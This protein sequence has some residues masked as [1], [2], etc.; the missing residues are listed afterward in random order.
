[1]VDGRRGIFDSARKEV[2][3]MDDAV[4]FGECFLGEVLMYELDGVGEQESLGGENQQRGS[5]GSS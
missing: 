5:S 1:M 3:L 4:P 2:E